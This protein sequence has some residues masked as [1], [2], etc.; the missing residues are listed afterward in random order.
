MGTLLCLSELSSGAAVAECPPLEASAGVPRPVHQSGASDTSNGNAMVFN[1]REYGPQTP[2]TRLQ[3]A[4][5]RAEAPGPS[6]VIL[7]ARRASGSLNR[8]LENTNMWRA[9]PKGSR[10]GA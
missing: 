8:E 4:G 1:L 10:A 3:G 5:D 7:N 9:W 2:A 6:R